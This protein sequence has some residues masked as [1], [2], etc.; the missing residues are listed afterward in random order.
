M[1]FC[2]NIGVIGR[3]RFCMMLSFFCY[4][5]SYF[6]FVVINGR[7]KMSSLFLQ[8][9]KTFKRSFVVLRKAN[10][11]FSCVGMPRFKLI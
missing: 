5:F 8:V 3:V 6:T 11:F 9:E 4:L 1:F 10:Y 2:L 7:I